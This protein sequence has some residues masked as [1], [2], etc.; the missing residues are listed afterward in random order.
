M[1]E[2]ALALA[3]DWAGAWQALGAVQERRSLSA[4]ARHAYA[5]ALRLDPSDRHGASLAMARLGAIPPP[6]AAPDAY[7]AA[8]FDDYATRFDTHLTRQL[9]YTGPAEIV[10]ALTSAG[11]ERFG[12]V[13]DLGCGTGLCGAALRS[14][15][16][17]LVG[18][19]LSPAMVAATRAK[20]I[21]DRLEVGGLHPFLAREPDARADLVVAV[22]V[23][24]YIGDLAPIVT[25][26]AR[27]LRS[28][29]VFAFSTQRSASADP[30]GIGADLRFHHTRP[31]VEA[32]LEAGSFA[33]LR[34]D[35][36]SIRRENG[37]EVAGLIVV[38]RRA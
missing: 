38:A 5:T 8:L 20:A 27:V 36:K 4:Q 30:Y 23:F 6:A 19:D 3:P 13:L 25:E 2:Q 33:V 11:T 31:Y 15:A 7:V 12:R 14:R 29:A 37:A 28:G 35:A 16:D 24:I 21:Y 26:A 32:I 10:A 22:D 1:M 34:C 18:V 17:H 9:H